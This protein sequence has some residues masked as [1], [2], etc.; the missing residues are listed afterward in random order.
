MIYDHIDTKINYEN[1][2]FLKILEVISNSDIY[3]KDTPELS[4]QHKIGHIQKVILFSQIIAQNENVDENQT[5]ILLAAAAFHDCGRM[6]DRDNDEHGISSARMTGEY[7]RENINNQYGIELNEIEIIQAAIEY[8]VIV[9]HI[10]GQIDEIK[11]KEICHK[12]S[13]KDKNYEKVRQISAIL[14]DADALDRARFVSGSDLNP[15]FLRTKTAKNSY[16]IEFSKRIN[17]EYANQVINVNY[18]AAQNISNNKIKLL[19]NIRHRYKI[20]NNGNRNKEIDIPL[21]IVKEIFNRDEKYIM[22]SN[23]YSKCEDDFEI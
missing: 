9:E 18:Y 7:F 1:S 22:E 16:M 23:I 8:H 13:V 5:K 12:Y 4:N 2:Q 3:K 6:K 10:P 17:E 19:H 21:D 11:L 15:A 20:E 14:K